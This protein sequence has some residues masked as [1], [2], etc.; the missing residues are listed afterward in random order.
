M[1][2]LQFL[3]A[4]FAGLLQ[5]GLRRLVKGRRR[6]TWTLMQE[7]LT[8]VMRTHGRLLQQQTPREARDLS[9][10]LQGM[11]VNTKGVQVSRVSLAELEARRFSAGGGPRPLMLYLHGGGYVFGSSDSYRGHLAR[12]AQALEIDVIAPDYRLAPEHPFPAALEDAVACVQAALRVADGPLVVAGDSAGG[13]LALAAAQRLTAAAEPV[14]AGLWL[15]SPWVDLGADTG[16]VVDNAAFDW[17]DQR[18]LDN[19]AAQYL[20][21]AD[22]RSAGASPAYDEMAGLPPI[23]LFFG[24]AEL[25]RDQCRLLADRAGRAGVEVS[26]HEDADMVHGYWMMPPAFPADGVLERTK[27]WLDRITGA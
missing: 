27:P 12:I 4:L 25:L 1:T 22:A 15:L 5:V 14:P 19:Y 18:Y 16:S 17:A 13:A 2:P 26:V 3:V 8:E 21:G 24:E 23:S 9:D 6:P 7:T 11:G 10:R 20:R